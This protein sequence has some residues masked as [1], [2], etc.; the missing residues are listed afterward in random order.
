MTGKQDAK[1]NQA[2]QAALD[3]HPDSVDPQIFIAR[4]KMFYGQL[5]E[6][7]NIID[8]IT[9]QD[10]LEVIYI[11][12]E[13]LI[14][15]GHATDASDF[16]LAQ[17]E[18][19][20]DCLDTFL[21]DCTSIFMDYDQWELAGQ[22]LEQ[23]KAAYPTHP[24]LPIMEAEIMMGLDNYESARDMLKEILE[25]EPYDSEAWNLLS[26]TY[27]ALEEYPEAIEAAD[28]ALAINPNDEGALLMKG[29]ASISLAYSLIEEERYKEALPLLEKAEH[30]AR[31]ANRDNGQQTTDNRQQ[32]TDN[33]QQTTDNGQQ[34]DLPQILQTKAF[35][36]SRLGRTESALAALAEARKLTDESLSWKYD[37]TEADICLHSG[38]TKQAE[39][40]F[41]SALEKS[42]DKGETLFNIAICYKSAG[43]YG[44][45]IDLL[46][47]VW[48]LAGT[49][50]GKFVVPHL[51]DCHLR[52]GE[53]EPFLEY[54]KL[55][56]YCDREATA[57]LFRDRFPG[58]EPED[59][60]NYAYKEVFGNFPSE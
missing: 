30:Y 43:H 51:A 26:E 18:Q 37:L 14:K 34:S 12:A 50:T 4:Q 5:D 45:A 10:D 11:R 6:A 15:E 41:V 53:M 52:L 55:S 2:I 16:L 22:W 29:N 27:V 25:S 59:Y 20:R 31:K 33:G 35:A 60:Y 28:F 49:E 58:L 32:T 19:M 21:Y 44:I 56:P 38:K 39:E 1:A 48:T 7:R 9:E 57:Y 23:L 47:D 40:L 17:M 46:C 13:L 3:M 54:L 8:S 24:R 42:P 36:L